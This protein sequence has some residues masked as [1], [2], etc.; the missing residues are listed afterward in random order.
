MNNKTNI[1]N[2]GSYASILR[3]VAGVSGTISYDKA[4]YERAMRM[5]REELQDA[6]YESQDERKAVRAAILV[7]I[8]N[9]GI[10]EWRAR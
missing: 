4:T 2:F 5:T 10:N 9:R 3:V 1:H 7:A 8:A 6:R